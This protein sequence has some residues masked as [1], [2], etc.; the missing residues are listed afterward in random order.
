MCFDKNVTFL[1]QYG[2]WV[3]WVE[4]I[5]AYGESEGELAGKRE[6]L[7][8]AAAMWDHGCGFG[9]NLSAQNVQWG[10]CYSHLAF[11]FTEIR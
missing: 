3:K 7:L 1:Q 4:A 8:I 5:R 2:P 6:A 11:G 9:A 10:D